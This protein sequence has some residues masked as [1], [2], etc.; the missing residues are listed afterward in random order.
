MV[1]VEFFESINNFGFFT[2]PDGV[3]LVGGIAN[4]L[5]VCLNCVRLGA[6]GVVDSDALDIRGGII[7]VA[8]TALKRRM[9]RC[10]IGL[11]LTALDGLSKT[12]VTEKR[13][14]DEFCRFVKIRL[15]AIA[16]D[17]LGGL[18]REPADGGVSNGVEKDTEPRRGACEKRRLP[19][20]IFFI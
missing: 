15:R 20:A 11:R 6:N 8:G 5:I 10:M 18:V 14:G 19:S 16:I 2:T 9:R 13:F 17:D 7:V 3:A 12:G 4:G 1:F